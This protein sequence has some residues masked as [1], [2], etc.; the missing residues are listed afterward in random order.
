MHTTAM[1][2]CE[3][4]TKGHTPLALGAM[5]GKGQLCAL[6]VAVRVRTLKR[7]GESLSSRSIMYAEPIC[8]DT[9]EGHA[10]L[11]QLIRRHDE[12]MEKKTLFAE[13][14]PVFECANGFDPFL[15]EGYQR[16]GYLNYEIRLDRSEEELFRSLSQKRR[17]NIRSA[18]RKGVLVAEIDLESGLKD[19]YSLVNESY[20][21]AQ[22]PVVHP[23]LFSAV[24][25]EFQP[26]QVR[27]LTAYYEGAPVATG[28]F[29]GHKKRVICWYAGMIRIPGVYATA[30]VFWE[31]M[32]RYAAQGYEVF[33][34]AGAGWEGEDY[35]PGKF[36]SKFGG[37]PTNHGRYRKVFAPWKAKAASIAYSAFRGWIS[38]KSNSR[39]S[40]LDSGHK[41]D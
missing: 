36:K 35:G 38:P 14:R 8:L 31:A 11:T 22:V 40:P 15:A 7:I 13:V 33:D 28:C 30:R 29:L 21:R 1:I 4:A 17:N 37:E 2:R 16:L 20:F 26:G 3:Q 39:V 27:L 23:S 34:L 9:P 10:G 32:K 6:L 25:R 41:V 12:F 18:D 24:A 5:N 19:F